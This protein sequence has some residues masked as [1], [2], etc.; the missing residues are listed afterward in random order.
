[1]RETP[2]TLIYGLHLP[3]VYRFALLMTGSVPVAA[4]VLRLT[5][6]QAERGDLSDV[7]DPRR[8]RRWLFA[9]ARTLCSRPLDLPESLGSPALHAD[10]MDP[11]SAD[12]AE[13]PVRR[14]PAL[15]G[16]LPEPERSALALFYLYVFL[17]DEL[18]EVLEVKPPVLTELLNRGRALLGKA[19]GRR[20]KVEVES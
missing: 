17:P 8:M 2:D 1:M 12:P 16:H 13:D 3:A 7:R 15:F 9:R 20:Q 19:E 18:A 6:E 4:E 10:G 11:A 14:L 5:V